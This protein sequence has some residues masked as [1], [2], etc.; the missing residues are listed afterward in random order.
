MKIR[1]YKQTDWPIIV[2]I[3]NRAKPD[4]LNGSVAPED[5]VG[6]QDD[7]ILYDSFKKSNIYIL[8][9]SDK[10]LGYAGNQGNLISF[11]FV[12]PEYYGHG[13]ATTLLEYLL[14]IIG[15]K[16]WL[17]VAKTNTPAINLYKKFGFSIVEEFTG[18]YNGKIEVSV[19]RLALNPKLQGWK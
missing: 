14:P 17:F 3:F 9:D 4:E 2:D 10:I 16:A 1:R 15:K 18:K 13:F 12:D 7:K 19:L 8:E 11:L 6:L 5:I